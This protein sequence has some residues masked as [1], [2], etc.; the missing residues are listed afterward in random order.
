MYKPDMALNNLQLSVFH[1][2]KRNLNLSL[3]VE[4]FVIKI[5]ELSCMRVRVN[6]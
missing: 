3:A 1:K 6:Y 5:E 2:T 4:M